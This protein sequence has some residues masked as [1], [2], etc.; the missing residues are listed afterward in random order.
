MKEHHDHENSYKRKHLTGA[1]L[2]VSEEYSIVTMAGSMATLM[3]TWSLRSRGFY[4]F[5]CRLQKGTMCHSRASSTN[6]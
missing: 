4:I 1:L 5:I 3:Q 6:I 2:R